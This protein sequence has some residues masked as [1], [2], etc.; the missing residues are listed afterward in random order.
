MPITA[1]R[2]WFLQ[3]LVMPEHM[4]N[5][6]SAVVHWSPW[7]F[8]S[9][10]KKVHCGRDPCISFRMTKC[11]RKQ[12]LIIWRGMFTARSQILERRLSELCPQFVRT[13]RV[14]VTPLPLQLFGCERAQYTPAKKSDICSY[15][16]T[17]D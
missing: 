5:H 13:L 16:I 17:V 11:H 2:R 15:E 8:L 12:L 10:F 9:S 14:L 3:Q 6:K 1:N 4:H 7:P